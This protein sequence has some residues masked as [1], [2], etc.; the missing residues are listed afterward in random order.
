M[1]GLTDWGPFKGISCKKN[2]NM[3]IHPYFIM[4][5]DRL[6]YGM[7]ATPADSRPYFR[8]SVLSMVV[9]NSSP[10][11]FDTRHYGDVYKSRY[12]CAAFSATISGGEPPLVRQM[13]GLPGNLVCENDYRAA[14]HFLLT[15]QYC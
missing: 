6:C 1:R 15:S 4:A 13:R 8:F 7:F 12:I 3:F 5:L 9:C 10:A 11:R 2:L 14:Q